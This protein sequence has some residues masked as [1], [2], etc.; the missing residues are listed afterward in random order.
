MRDDKANDDQILGDSRDPDSSPTGSVDD[1][2]AALVEHIGRLDPIKLLCNLALTHLSQDANTFLGEADEANRWVVRIEIVAGILLARPYPS[3][4]IP[5]ITVTDITRLHQ[6]I[7]FYERSLLRAGYEE[8]SSADHSSE[9]HIIGSVRNYAF[10]VRG[11]A[12]LHQYSAM[13]HALYSPHQDWFKANLGFTADEAMLL[14]ESYIEELN[15]RINREFDSASDHATKL[16]TGANCSESTEDE[17]KSSIFYERYFGRADEIIGYSVDDFSRTSGLSRGTC[18][19][20]LD[21]LSQEFGY[22]NPKYPDVFTDAKSAPWDYNTLYER[23]FLHHG[24]RYWMVLP[25]I[26]HPALM[27]TF[28]YDL[29]GDKDYRS[30]FAQSRGEWL[31]RKT[32]DC[33]KDVFAANQVL[34]NPYYANGKELADVLVLYDRKALVVQCKSKGLTFEASMG[35]DAEALRVSLEKAVKNA[36]EQG[37]RAR[38]FLQDNSSVTVTFKN[39]NLRCDIDTKQI[40]RIYLV[41]VTAQPLQFLATRWAN[42]NAELGLFPAGDYPWC[43]S[44]SDLEV[45][46]EI[47][48]DPVR[49]LH[50]VNRRTKIELGNLVFS[51]DELDLVGMY[52][53][54]GLYFEGN[55]YKDIDWMNLAGMSKSID[56]YMHRKYVLGEPVECPTVLESERFSEFIAAVSKCSAPYSSNVALAVLDMSSEDREGFME[57]VTQTMDRTNADREPHNCSVGIAGTSKAIS[58]VA[59]D[60]TGDHEELYRRLCAL[61]SWKV[62]QGHCTEFF[63][64]GWDISTGKIV[65]TTFYALFGHPDK[66]L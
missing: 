19:K 44:I 43:L 20:I 39:S 5:D 14:V 29:M 23:P 42:I 46:C 55:E 57:L 4:P 9:S 28:Y 36:F 25:A 34:L 32:A 50:Y 13:S 27:N 53:N 26:V 15:N 63:G 40:D 52:L 12:Y 60:A 54:Q 45:L 33:F 30:T 37:R 18:V 49:L 59:M 47:F 58:F 2:F 66:D 10:W 1:A 61:A 51:G 22:R 64:I 48:P 62:Q 16:A 17:L 24:Q 41:V 6:L 7:E 11:T 35:R 56:E 65:D 21:R 8:S 31:E 3:D 38:Q